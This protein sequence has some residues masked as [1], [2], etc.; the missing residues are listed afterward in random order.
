MTGVMFDRCHM[1]GNQAHDERK[2]IKAR[3]LD[4][5]HPSGGRNVGSLPE[6]GR[7]S[8]ISFP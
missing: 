7:Q 6:W 8:R 1:R 4:G 3:E 2:Q 5:K